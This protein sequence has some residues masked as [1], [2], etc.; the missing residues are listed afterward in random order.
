M[1]TLCGEGKG[2]ATPWEEGETTLC[3]EGKGG[4]NTLGGGGG[5]TVWGGGEW[6]DILVDVVKQWRGDYFKLFI[7]FKC[8]ESYKGL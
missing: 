1:S 8:K 2:G 5:N 3:G 4:G 7:V 6:G